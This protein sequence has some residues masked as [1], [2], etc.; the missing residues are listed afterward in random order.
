MGKP[1][2]ETAASPSAH[3]RPPLPKSVAIF[4]GRRLLAAPQVHHPHSQR[5]LPSHRPSMASHLRPT[6]GYPPR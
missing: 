1:D 5:P 2:N 3:P 6:L 4:K